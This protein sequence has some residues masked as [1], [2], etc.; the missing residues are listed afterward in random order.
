MGRSTVAAS[1]RMVL[2]SGLAAM[3]IQ[4]VVTTVFA[5]DDDA[6]PFVDSQP[7]ADLPISGKLQRYADRI[8]A[9][10]DTSGDLVL[11]KEEWS[12]MRG[13]PH[14]IDQSGDGLVT[15]AEFSQH[16]AWFSRRHQIRLVSPATSVA[17][18]SLG[19]LLHPI[20]SGTEGNEFDPDKGPE[21]EAVANGD[22][23]TAGTDGGE[24]AKDIP[25]VA[26]R[27]DLKFYVPSSRLPSGLPSWFHSRDRDGDG[28]VSLAEFAPSMTAESQAQF[29]AMDANSDGL[30]VPKEVLRAR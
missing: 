6:A 17:N 10:Y 13:S 19:P 14:L 30:L 22:P 8:I 3:C 23:N 24:P 20:S 11:Q 28:Q 27:G 18:V 21:S 26:R 15:V 5:N 12:Q 9:R 29:K 2:L 25:S 1:V 7:A 16:V 4:P